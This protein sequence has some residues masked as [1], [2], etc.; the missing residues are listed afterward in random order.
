MSQTRNK[1]EF[2][3]NSKGDA[4]AHRESDDHV[5]TPKV[6]ISSRGKE[7]DHKTPLHVTSSEMEELLTHILGELVIMN[8]YFQTISDVENPFDRN[9]EPLFFESG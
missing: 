3:K 4:L 8:R 6:E 1:R 5:L 7:L 2:I 9:D